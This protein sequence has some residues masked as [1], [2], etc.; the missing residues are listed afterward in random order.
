MA[1]EKRYPIDD[2]LDEIRSHREDRG[3]LSRLRR[4]LPS[5][6][7]D[8]AWGILVAQGFNFL[9][10]VKRRIWLTIGAVAAMLEPDNLVRTDKGENLG[11]VLHGLAWEKGKKPRENVS[12]TYETKL[13]R[14]LNCSSTEELCDLAVGVCRMAAAKGIPVNCRQLYFDLNGWDDPDRREKTRVNWTIQYHRPQEGREGGEE[15]S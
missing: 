12:R 13:R 7:E 8:Q 6:T 4:G 3:Y 5:T 2:F 15:L 11:A 10:P 14:L 1:N 9:D